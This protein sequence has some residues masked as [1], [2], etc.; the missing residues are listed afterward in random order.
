[1]PAAPKDFIIFNALWFVLIFLFFSVSKSK[2]PTY[3]LPV[4]IP[5]SVLT[6]AYLMHEEEKKRSFRI[7]VFI[8]NSLFYSALVFLLF[9]LLFQGKYDVFES[10]LVLRVAVTSMVII[11]SYVFISSALFSGR[12]KRIFFTTA[13]FSFFF[14]MSLIFLAE[15]LSPYYSQSEVS[16][17]LRP[18][19]K[20]NDVVVSYRRYLQ[21]ANFY[22]KRRIALIQT[23]SE[24]EVEHTGEKTKPYFLDT[25]EDFKT[26]LE[27]HRVFCFVP[28]KDV[29]DF[30]AFYPRDMKLHYLGRGKNMLL[31]SNMNV[32]LKGQ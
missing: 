25:I 11:V 3:I 22:T 15:A 9:Y 6:A 7:T 20:K 30:L 10:G 29:D 18:G 13:V 5:M 19:L 17:Y 4:F 8:V 23:I 26:L 1:M 14:L 2:L 24:L 31:F 32:M 28:S 27:G 21:T 12:A 16:R